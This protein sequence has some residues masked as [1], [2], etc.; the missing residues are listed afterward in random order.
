MGPFWKHVLKFWERRNQEN[1]MFLTYEEMKKV[2][3]YWVV[4]FVEEWNE[5]NIFQD[6]A[7]VI[8]KTAK[9][10]NKTIT[11][12][13]VEGLSKHL[14]FSSMAANPAVNLEYLL[15]QKKSSEQN[16]PDEK[17]IRKG[18][19]GDWRNYMSEELSDRFDEWT[20]RNLKN[21]GLS[22][23]TVSLEIEEWIDHFSCKNVIF[24]EH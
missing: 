6:Q 9:F 16:D 8:R 10:L 19:V 18:K 7:G 3:R 13:Q 17:F 14:T 4:P 22:F 5:M 20:E 24:L 2:K 11:D 15:A 12:K 23:D 1:I 21:T